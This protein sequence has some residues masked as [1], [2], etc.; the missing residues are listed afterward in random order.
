MGHFSRFTYMEDKFF[1]KAIYMLCLLH[2]FTAHEF[3]QG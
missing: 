3:Y 1:V 2:D